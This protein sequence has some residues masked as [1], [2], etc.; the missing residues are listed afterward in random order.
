MGNKLHEL[1]TL[2]SKLAW[3]M[4]RISLAIKRATSSRKGG[5]LPF[6]FLEIEKKVLILE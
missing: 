4:K 1:K 6:P 5:G 2:V 3:Q